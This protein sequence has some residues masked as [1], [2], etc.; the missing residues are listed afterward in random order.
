MSVC[1]GSSKL[2]RAGLLDGKQATT[3]HAF[4]KR[5]PGGIS[6]NHLGSRSALRGVVSDRFDRQGLPFRTV[7]SKPPSTRG[8]IWRSLHVS[9]AEDSGVPVWYDASV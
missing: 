7:R 9:D 8:R 5:L 2:A 4:M 3:H 1:I 6:K